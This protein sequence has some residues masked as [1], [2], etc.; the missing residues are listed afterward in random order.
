M[1]HQTP[2]FWRTIPFLLDPPQDTKSLMKGKWTIKFERKKAALLFPLKNSFPSLGCPLCST[3]PPCFGA[4]SPFLLDPPQD[5]KSPM[6]GKWTIKFER[7]KA[8]L[9]FPLKNS[10]PSFKIPAHCAPPNPPVLVHY[11]PSHLILLRIQNHH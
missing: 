2:L 4:L 7:K 11:P 8:A 9:L 3:K 5:T 10:L 1:L 6:K